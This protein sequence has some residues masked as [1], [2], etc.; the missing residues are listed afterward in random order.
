MGVVIRG[1]KTD[2][3]DVVLLTQNEDNAR[4]IAEDVLVDSFMFHNIRNMN[5][6]TGFH[7]GRKIT[8][9]GLG[10]GNV[11]AAMYVEEL[12]KEFEPKYLFKLDGCLALNENLKP[13][14]LVLA[15][16]VHTTSRI[17]RYNY[18][19]KVF[20][21]AADFPL[22]NLSYE[23]A[24]KLDFDIS[25]GPIVSIETRDEMEIARKFAER[26]ALCIDLE[27]SQVYT[28]ANRAGIPVVG[29]L[30]VF[31]NDVSKEALTASEREEAFLRL[32]DLALNSASALDVTRN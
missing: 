10:I 24:K 30:S 20:P 16:T 9:Q 31:E 8:V 6:Y 3:A 4:K 5:G 13:G 21:A 12:I 15:Q 7:N 14:E 23:K 27:L 22:L 29:L 1:K 2:V 19:G 17:N 32:V 26:G 11:S 28:I 25:V 18:G